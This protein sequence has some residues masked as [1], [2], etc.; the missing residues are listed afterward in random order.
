MIELLVKFYWGGMDQAKMLS[1]DQMVNRAARK[2]IGNDVANL[3]VAHNGSDAI[4]KWTTAGWR[5][6]ISHGNSLWI[7]EQ[8]FD[9]FKTRLEPL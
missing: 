3:S 5:L 7:N 4:V 8:A 9:L 2:I 6:L 1:D